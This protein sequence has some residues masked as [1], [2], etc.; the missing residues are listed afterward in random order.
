MHKREHHLLETAGIKN[1]LATLV[2]KTVE[3]HDRK[4]GKHFAGK[5][6][7]AAFV[8]LEPSVGRDHL[9]LTI[10][11][12]GAPMRFEIEASGRPKWTISFGY[13]DNVE[14]LEIKFH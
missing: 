12:P 7:S 3:I 4:F 6:A 9:L 1:G 2:G 14:D 8:P 13:F 5:I 11:G 10:E